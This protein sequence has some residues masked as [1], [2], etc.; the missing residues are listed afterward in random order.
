MNTST[1]FYVYVHSR[2]S[3][4]TPFYVGK[5]RGRRAYSSDSRSKF[6][7][8]VVAKNGGRTVSFIGRDMD[9]ELAFLV[10]SES[11]DKLRR[12]GASLVNLTDGGDGPKGRIV[13]ETTREKL[14]LR[15]ITP[16]WRAKMSAAARRRKLT[17]EQ[18]KAI[19]GRVKA[20][21]LVKPRKPPS[22]SGR[23]H[24]PYSRAKMSAAAK[25]RVSPRKGKPVTEV[26]RQH[27]ARI[28]R[29]GVEARWNRCDG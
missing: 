5:G 20:E 25:G 2:L 14:R 26:A 23:T 12:C 17:P 16:E 29:L 24:S 27:L 3:S 18:C 9:E 6:W 1:A 19:S 21:C 7:R 10:E 28:S 4:G 11:I 8:A 15:V 22:F 13:N